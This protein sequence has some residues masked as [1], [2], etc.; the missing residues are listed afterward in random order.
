M[1]L[2]SLITRIRGNSSLPRLG[3]RPLAQFGTQ[4]RP[5]RGA[6]ILPERLVPE[7]AYR[8]DSVRYRTVIA[9]DGTRYSP[10]QLKQGVLGGSVL[11]ELGDSDIASEL[12]SR[13]YDALLRLLANSATMEAEANILNFLDVTINRALI[14]KNEK[15]RWE[16]L[17]ARLIQRRGDN[18]FTEDVPISSPAGHMLYA[19]DP[20]SDPAVDPFDEIGAACQVL[21]DKGYEPEGIVTRSQVTAIMAANPNVKT[22]TGRVTITSGGVPTLVGLG[23]RTTLSEINGQMQADNNPAIEIYDRRYHTQTGSTPFIEDGAMV[24][25]GRT[26]RTEEIALDNNE[27]ELLEG[28]LGYVGVGRA[29]G[30]ADPGRVIRAEHKDDKPPR[31]EAEGWQTSG[32]VILDP[33]AF[34]TIRNI[35][36]GTP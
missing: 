23:G 17:V 6:L 22:R 5:Y 10:T 12:T 16:A 29:A 34:V 30:Q 20:W 21:R 24:I 19:A 36:V 2:N 4:N 28:T 15:Y 32:P 8:E 31:I 9:N 35:H 27:M 33:E 13:D 3:R 11:V 7:N 26:E 25:Y 18:G 1:D 14:E